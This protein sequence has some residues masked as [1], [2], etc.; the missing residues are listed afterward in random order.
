MIKKHKL[1]PW[2]RHELTYCSNVHP[3]ETVES[4]NT[5]IAFFMNGVRLARNLPMMGTGL[6]LSDQVSME[7]ASSSVKRDELVSLLA[8]NKINLFTLNGF[9]FGNFHAK[10]V[11]EQV[12]TP[13]WSQLPRYNYTLR[14]AKILAD[15]LPDDMAEGTISTLPLGFRYTWTEQQHDAALDALCRLADF[16][17]GLHQSS[18]RSIRVCLEM[19]PDCVLETT[20]EM[21][22]FFQHQLPAKALALGISENTI[23]NHL[24]VCFDVCHQA[25]MFEDVD[26]SMARLLAADIVIGKIQ[27]SSA[28]ELK[29]P[30]QESGLQ[31]LHKFAEQKYLHQVRTLKNNNLIGSV[32]LAVAFETD[33]FPKTEPWR[34]HFHVPIQATTLERQELDTTQGSILKVL[35]F[36]K[37]N[38]ECHPHLEVET[39]TWQVLPVSL[40]PQND[41]AL[42]NGL[43]AE[44]SW[45][46]K[47]MS[48]RGLLL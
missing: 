3:A 26:L 40:R 28:L 4:L 18:G 7:L 17:A 31:V 8:S 11:K 21:L 25:V 39:Y 41:L 20:E 34:V 45:L 30:D 10:S 47:Q 13:D 24:G 23:R 46:E 22:H 6:W 12:Y 27:I 16:L 32:D 48:L 9:P 19:E 33:N 37:A 44:L 15:C 1:R 42:I 5:V 38:P 35:D 14:L 2:Q 29:C 36:L 43:T